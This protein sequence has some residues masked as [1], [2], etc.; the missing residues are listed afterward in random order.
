MTYAMTFSRISLHNVQVVKSPYVWLSR[1]LRL[2]EGDYK[3]VYRERCSPSDC[4]ARFL[5]LYNN[6]A[7]CFPKAVLP[8]D[9]A[10]SR[11]GG[12]IIVCVAASVAKA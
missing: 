8:D 4:H 3:L 12:E 2:D 11:A 1:L 6:G 10:L 5:V 9:C 7:I